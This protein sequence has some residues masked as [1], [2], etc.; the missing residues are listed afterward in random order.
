MFYSRKFCNFHEL[1]GNNK[2]FTL[3]ASVTAKT[4][5][6]VWVSFETGLGHLGQPCHVLSGSSWLYPVYK[7]SR[8]DP[9]SN[10]DHIH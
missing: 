10:L 3:I 4:L 7:T 2:S 8:S 5:R 6:M 9:D 1:C